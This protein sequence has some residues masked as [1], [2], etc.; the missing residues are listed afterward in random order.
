M[1]GC[2]DATTRD[3]PRARLSTSAKVPYLPEYGSSIWAHATEPTYTKEVPHMAPG[4]RRLG[5]HTLSSPPPLICCVAADRA[6]YM[7]PMEQHVEGPVAGVPPVRRYGVFC[8]RPP[9]ACS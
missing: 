4:T 6:D 2:Y 1:P 9:P 3:Q 5:L 8:A 7:H